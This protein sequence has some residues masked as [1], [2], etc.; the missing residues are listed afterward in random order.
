MLRGRSIRQERPRCNE[1]RTADARDL[2]PPFAL[3]WTA[4]EET[5]LDRQ[6]P[7]RGAWRYRPHLATGR[8]LVVAPD[9]LI[10]VTGMQYVPH[11]GWTSYDVHVSA[12]RESDGGESLE[13][14][15][16]EEFGSVSL[17]LASITQCH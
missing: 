7:L 5:L 1:P 14:I 4:P 17:E 3:A 16:Q 11:G 10:I 2:R 13:A 15:W 12:L 8:G 9:G 6:G